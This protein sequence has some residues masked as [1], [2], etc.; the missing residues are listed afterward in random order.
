ML[1]K[2]FWSH[3]V[4][5]QQKHAHYIN[6][7]MDPLDNPLTTRPIQTGWELSI[8][9]YPNWQFRC[10]D[11]LDLIF[12]NGSVLTR[13]RTWSGGLELLLTLQALDN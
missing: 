6:V 7:Q 3:T 11:D 4:I 2:W 5:Q 1:V 8:E 9:L 10:I 12:G 13:T